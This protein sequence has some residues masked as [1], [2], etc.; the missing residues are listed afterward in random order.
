MRALA[1][2]LTVLVLVSA[3]QTVAPRE[4]TP[5]VARFRLETVDAQGEWLTLPKSAVR[6]AV[7]AKPV[8]TEFDIVDV[9][10]AEVQLG[11]CLKFE[12]TTAA[13]RDLFRLTSV[14]AGQRLVLLVNGK[15]LGARRIDRAIHDGTLLIFVETPD[16]GLPALSENLLKTALALQQAA[17]K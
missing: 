8:M 11:K 15:P 4:Y 13:G 16:E 14:N 2:L 17:A 6:I 10:M 12:F 3:C 9:G 1:A 5:M 7:G